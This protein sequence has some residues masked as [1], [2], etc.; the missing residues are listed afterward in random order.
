[1]RTTDI[2]KLYKPENNHSLTQSF[3]LQTDF[4]SRLKACVELRHR[5][6]KQQA[7]DETIEAAMTASESQIM[8]TSHDE[9]EEDEDSEFKDPLGEEHFSDHCVEEEDVSG[10]E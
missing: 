8:A 1:V 7:L 4:P 10:K 6:A 3:L 9:E 2:Q 5:R